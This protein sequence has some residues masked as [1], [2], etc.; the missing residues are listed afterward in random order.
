MPGSDPGSTL[1]ELLTLDELLNLPKRD[2]HLIGF[3]KLSEIKCAK[4]IVG[5]SENT[6]P[7]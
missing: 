6:T 1:H 5:V 2:D 3:M 7:K 4:V